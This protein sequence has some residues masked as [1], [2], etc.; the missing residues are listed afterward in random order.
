MEQR[1][2]QGNKQ[3]EKLGELEWRKTSSLPEKYGSVSKFGNLKIDRF[4]HSNLSF[5]ERPTEVLHFDIRTDLYKFIG[6]G[7]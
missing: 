3:T 4:P 1:K 5:V 2:K 7:V 6:Y